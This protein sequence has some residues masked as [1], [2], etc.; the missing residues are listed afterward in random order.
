MI[1]FYCDCCGKGTDNEHDVSRIEIAD[2]LR[3][4]SEVYRYE[5]HLCAECTKRAL[6]PIL[7]VGKKY[8]A[9]DRHG[10]IVDVEIAEIE[11]V[12]I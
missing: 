6:N 2:I 7:E 3:F 4:D 9:R 11:A 5:A 12:E 8:R 1:K 10:N